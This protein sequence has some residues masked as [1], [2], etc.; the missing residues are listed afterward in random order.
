MVDDDDLIVAMDDAAADASDADGAHVARVIEHADL[1]LERRVRI[2]RRRRAVLDD[3]A[4]QDVHVAVH[5][6]GRETRGTEQRRGID[7]GEVK[8]R[9]RRAEPVEKIEGLVEHPV[10]T[11]GVAIHLV[12]HDDGPEAVD[13]GLLGDEAGLRSMGASTASTGAAHGVDHRQHAFDLAAESA[14]PGVSTMLMR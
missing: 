5:G 4:E 14:W 12:D 3:G 11:R 7:D 2:D 10:R 1:E 13:E 6:I 9:L 8:L